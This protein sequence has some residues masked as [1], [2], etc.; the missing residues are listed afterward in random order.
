MRLSLMVITAL[1]LLLLQSALAQLLPASL[2]PPAFAVLA[3]LHLGM[4]PRWSLVGQVTLAFTFGYL[5]DLLAGAPHGSHALVFTLIVL[6]VG[7]VARRVSVA[8]VLPRMAACFIVA[9]VSATAVVTLRALVSRSGGFIGL[10]W[11]P[12]EAVVTALV[13]P[14]VLRL[15][16]RIEGKA[17]KRRIRGAFRRKALGGGGQLPLG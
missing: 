13:G 12:V 5:F 6:A 4:S 7:R 11:A 15:L 14:A 9:L 17:G 3:V 2:P 8:R 1:V 16:E 10:R